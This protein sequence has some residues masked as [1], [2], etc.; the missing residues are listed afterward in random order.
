MNLDKNDNH[1]M[2]KPNFPKESAFHVGFREYKQAL[3]WSTG[4]RKYGGCFEKVSE[5]YIAYWLPK[6]HPRLSEF[7]W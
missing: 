6:D 2:V 7:I 4:K 3:L 1:L 5:G